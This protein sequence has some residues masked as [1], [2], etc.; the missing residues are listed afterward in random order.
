MRTLKAKVRREGY[1]RKLVVVGLG[2]IGG[3]VARAAKERGLAEEVIGVVRREE[4]IREAMEKGMVNHATLNLKEALK[5]ADLVFLCTPIKTVIEQIPLLASSVPEGCIVTDVGST[6]GAIMEEAREAFQKRRACFIGGHPM[7]GSEKGGM[8]ASRPDMFEGAVYILIPGPNSDSIRRKALEE[9]VRGLG[10][11]PFWM[12]D[13]EEHDKEVAI[14]SHLPHATACALSRA[15]FEALQGKTSKLFAGGFSD[16]TR[17]ASGPASVWGD[18]FETNVKFLLPLLG[19]LRRKVSDLERAL[20]TGDKE[21][22]RAILK[23]AKEFRE[24]ALPDLEGK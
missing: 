18:I 1:P 10:A 8:E 11:N 9:F 23:E 15:C 4:A 13:P 21:R 17:I 14:T 6:K 7:T 24:K 22:L 2:C 3:S 5:E 12:D 16:T 20:A 19:I